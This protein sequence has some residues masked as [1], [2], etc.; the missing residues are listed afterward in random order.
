MYIYAITV[1]VVAF[2][3]IA[4]PIMEPPQQPGA[5]AGKGFVRLNFGLAGGRT[6]LPDTYFFGGYE[7]TFT[8]TD[9]V[10]GRE[11]ETSL[12]LEDEYPLEIGNWELSV[13]LYSDA[14]RETLLASA[15]PIALEVERGVT[16]N[17]TVPLVFSAMSGHGTFI[18]TITATGL[19]PAQTEI[20]LERLDADQDDYYYYNPASL[21]EGYSVPS[22]H[23]LV[24]VRLEKD[25]ITSLGYSEFHQLTRVSGAKRAVWSDVVHFYPGQTTNLAH[26]FDQN[27]LFNGIENVWLFGHMTDI[28]WNLA[29]LSNKSM[30]K[31]ADG[32]FSWKGDVAANSYFRF[33]LTDTSG[34]GGGDPNMKGGAWFI[35]G[36]TGTSAVIGNEGNAMNFLPLNHNDLPAVEK[37]WKLDDAG[38]YEITLDPVEWKFHVQKPLI[39]ETVTITDG[40]SAVQKGAT[41]NEAFAAAVTGKNIPAN[42]PITW[43]VQGTIAK[44]A[45]TGINTAGILSIDGDET[46][47]SL[48]VT[49]VYGGVIS[50][51]RQVSL[52]TTPVLA[53]PAAPTL[54]AAG[55]AEWSYT[56]DGMV[57]GYELHLYKAGTAMSIFTQSVGAGVFQYD[58]KDNIRAAGLGVYH[59]KLTAVGDDITAITSPASDDSNTQTVTPRTA[60]VHT[61]WYYDYAQWVNTDTAGDYIIQLYK[62]G[63][64]IGSEIEVDRAEENDPDSGGTKSVHN[65]AAVKA[66]N[67]VGLYTFRVKAKGDDLVLDS[68]WSEVS[69]GNAGVTGYS[70]F[71]DSKVWTI[72]EGGGTFVAGGDGGKIAWSTDKM[73]WTLSTQTTFDPESE[74]IRG[75]AYSSTLGSTDPVNGRFVAVG[76]GGKIAYSDDLGVS[77]T[78][79]VSNTTTPRSPFDNFGVLAIAYDG[80]T[81]YAGGD[82]GRIASSTDGIEWTGVAGGDED[83]PFAVLSILSI[84]CGDGIFVAVGANGRIAYFGPHTGTGGDG[85]D[86]TEKWRWISDDLFGASA[87]INSVTFGNGVFVAAGAGGNIKLATAD[88]IKSYDDKWYAWGDGGGSST[89]AVTSGFSGTTIHNIIYN[90]SQFRAVGD[91]GKMSVSSNGTTWL[92][93]TVGTQT[94]FNEREGITAIGF[95]DGSFILH[96]YQYGDA[97]NPNMGKMVV[98]TPQ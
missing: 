25:P 21:V 79:A 81:F 43:D 52:T 36:N 22:G 57:S 90:G 58:L 94:Q 76:Y 64:V 89:T 17:V 15:A 62:D 24:T 26:T 42:P 84:A 69:S 34:W 86:P 72:V 63:T 49:A 53:K 77:W 78:V 13:K 98:I 35:P 32:T 7:F 28:D 91:N 85:P 23:Y 71:G 82:D 59:V 29:D 3:L 68:D 66:T 4:C 48:T 70:P 18:Y 16:K 5:E 12:S 75:I 55:L 95:G 14:A 10:N 33:S 8:P 92:A 47:T 50:E 40:P 54:S 65:S 27:D 87:A 45:G 46:N 80:T 83:S 73:H 51:P 74:S 60:V 6:L 67:G 37:T 93:Q 38:Y 20:I 19:T 41:A 44:A 1:L 56:E 31:E 2:S 9:P 88:H 97:P 61:W 39:V 96:G 11:P 30:T